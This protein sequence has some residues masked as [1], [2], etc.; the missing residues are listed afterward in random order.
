MGWVFVTAKASAR[1]RASKDRCMRFIHT[2]T[3]GIPLLLRTHIQYVS[4]IDN[5][6]KEVAT[7]VATFLC[8]LAL[9]S[10]GEASEGANL[11]VD[12]YQSQLE[13]W[14][15]RASLSILL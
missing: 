9:R 3:L 14:A 13:G 7:S 1:R 6:D 12:Q 10:R 15:L 5:I 8:V 4:S 2:S 11:M